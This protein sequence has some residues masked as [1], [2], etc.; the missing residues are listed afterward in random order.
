MK[1]LVYAALALCFITCSTQNNDFNTS[2]MSEYKGLL[3]AQGITSYQYGTHT[4]Q[5]KDSLYA[6]KS[7]RVNLDNYIGKTITLTAE[8]IE[9]YP[10]DGGPAYLNVIGVK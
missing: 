4:L 1:T 8:P 10:V 7:E 5:T 9:G 6:L 2:P 3:Q